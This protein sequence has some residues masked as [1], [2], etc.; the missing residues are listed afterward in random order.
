MIDPGTDV[1]VGAV[2]DLRIDRIAGGGEGV[3]RGPDGRA[4]FVGG[5]LPGEQVTAEVTEVRRRHARARLV[6]VIDPSPARREP[7]CPHVAE[8]CGGCDWQHAA[9]ATQSELRLGL[10]VDALSRIGRIDAPPVEP[11]VPLPPTATRTT[12]RAAVVGGRAGFRRRRSHDL[13]VPDTC[14]IAHPAA[15][16][17]LVDGRFGSADEVTIRVGARTGER[18]VVVGPSAAG[19]E[20]PPDV[21]VVGRDEVDRTGVVLHEE[22]GGR[23][24]Q[25]SPESFFQASAEGAD[26]LVEEVDGAV[27]L[28]VAH[29]VPTERLVD[30]CAGVGLFAGTVGRRVARVV[31]VESSP[32]AVADARSNLDLAVEVV[33]ATMARWTPGPADVVVADPPRVGLESAGVAAVVATGAAG[34]VL[35]SCD[36]GSLGRDARLLADAGYRLLRSRV[37]DLF[38]QTSHV[39]VVSTFLSDPAG[40]GADAD[41]TGMRP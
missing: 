18:M 33:T 29:G 34:V 16:E 31:A 6:T 37:L 40:T 15:E 27:D 39:E 23:R 7:P 26:A 35:V 38:P 36:P 19:V 41:A 5:T 3:G 14:L 2:V 25:V 10:V 11:G 4:V 28:L 21:V 12:L 32:S 17:L 1:E 20:V 24:W 13:V 9:P 8:G 30:L 22:A